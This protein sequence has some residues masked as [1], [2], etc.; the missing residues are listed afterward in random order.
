MKKCLCNPLDHI[1]GCIVYLL[2]DV[3]NDKNS[4][5]L[6]FYIK[7]QSHLLP[8]KNKKKSSD[9]CHFAPSIFNP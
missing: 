9:C 2:N 8:V 4:I 3:S 7:V 1:G 5:F 6:N